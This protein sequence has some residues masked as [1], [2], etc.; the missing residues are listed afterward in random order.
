[1]YLITLMD[2]YIC[3]W[4]HIDAYICSYMHTI[5]MWMHTYAYICIRISFPGLVWKVII[6]QFNLEMTRRES[7]Q[8]V[9]NIWIFKLNDCAFASPERFCFGLTGYRFDF[10]F[11]SFG[12]FSTV[13]FHFQVRLAINS[14]QKRRNQFKTLQWRWRRNWCQI[15]GWLR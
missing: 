8:L 6:L 1:M 15:R 5:C 7:F 11:S 10:S 4:L 14:F 9:I 12:F 3:I 13:G 2:S